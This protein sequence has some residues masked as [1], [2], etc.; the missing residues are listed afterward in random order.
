[1]GD[2]I[3]WIP[4]VDRADVVA[5]MQT[6]GALV[7]PSVY[8]GFGL[9]V[10]EAMACGCPVVCSDI[11]V[12]REVTGGRALFAPPMD[13]ARLGAAMAQAAGSESLRRDLAAAGL[14]RASQLSWDR[15]AA[16]TLAVYREAAAARTPHGSRCVD[17]RPA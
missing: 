8:E 17:E 3:V 15:C 9:P 2:R 11:S 4:R 10:I 5:L 13:V 14:E 7:Q 6:A 16:E 1:V 12:F